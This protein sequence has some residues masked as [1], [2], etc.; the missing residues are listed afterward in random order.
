[1]K[2][3][4]ITGLF[5]EATAEQINKI[6][7]INGADINTAKKGVD[8]LQKAHQEALETI[9]Q[10]QE[11]AESTNKQLETFEAT[12]SELEALKAANTIREMREKVSKSMNIPVNLLTGE[13]EEACMEQAKN[14]QEYVKP[15]SYPTVHDGGEPSGTPTVST[16]DQ[17]ANWF[18]NL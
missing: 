11:T 5:P 2:R 13:T 18:N 17:F 10:L 3:E 6:M 15:S 1:M 16:R 7:S 4:D 12:K 8:D 9:K 14:I